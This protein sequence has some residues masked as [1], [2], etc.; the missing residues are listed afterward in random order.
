MPGKRLIELKQE[1]ATVTNSIRNIMTEFEGK[2]MEAVK[3]EELLKVENR[4]DEIND[5]ILKEEK[6][7]NRER[8]IGEKQNDDNKTNNEGRVDEAQAAF[9]DYIISGSKQAFEVYAALQQDNPTQA[10]YLVAPEQF[11]KEIIKGI[12][13]VFI[14]RQKGKVLPALKEAKSLGYPQRTAR[15]SNFTWGTELS[16]PTA[17]T[18][19]SVGKREFKPNPGSLEILVS[20]TLL[21]NAP[22]AEG[23]IMSE[24]TFGVGESLEKAYM[25]GTGFNQP[26]GL[27]TASADGISIARDVATGNT[28]TSMTFDGLIEAKYSIKDQY[29]KA[30]EWIFHRDGVKQIAK[31]K[32]GDGQYIW[33]PSVVAG[34]PDM[35]LSKPVNSSEYAPNTFTSGLYTGLYGDLSWYWMCDAL[36]MEM[37]ILLELYARSNQV[38][39]ILR[40]ETDGAPVLE[41]AF[42]RVKLG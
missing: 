26:L 28:A 3:K 24:L 23:F 19:L 39:Y 30:C 7:L 41:E 40:I 37:Q 14:M 33:Q 15:V 35:L 29:Q 17:D 2:E 4:F 25:A 18:A 42:A 9:K 32:D 10:G 20:K 5:L 11:Q 16:T 1:R 6:Q 38:D 31:I 13:N 27:F 36:T 8:T 12:D 34:T 22:Y 21:R